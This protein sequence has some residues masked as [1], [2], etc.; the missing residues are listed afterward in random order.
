MLYS[1]Q[2]YLEQQSTPILKQLLR[3]YEPLSDDDY[4]AYLYSLIRTILFLRGTLE[5]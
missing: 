1:I 5:E 3:Q 2:S 4:Y